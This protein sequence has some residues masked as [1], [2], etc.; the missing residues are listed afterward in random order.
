MHPHC[1]H[2]SLCQKEESGPGLRI[3]FL[4]RWLGDD[5]RWLGSVYHDVEASTHPYPLS[6]GEAP[7]DSLFPVVWD[8]DLGSVAERTG[9]FTT[10]IALEPHKDSTSLG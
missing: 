1:I 3:G 7:P 4:S 10:Y 6:E 5:V 8:C 2:A 9:R